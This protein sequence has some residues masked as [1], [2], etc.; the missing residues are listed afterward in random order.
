MTTARR[1]RIHAWPGIERALAKVNLP[2]AMERAF[3]RYS[4]QD[5]LVTPVGELL[6]TKPSGE[7]HIKSGH[8]LGDDI[9]VVKVATG[10]YDNARLGL[11]TSSGVVLAFSAKT[12]LPTDILLDEG[13]LT[14][15]R[16]AAAGAVAAKYLAPKKV[17]AIGILGSGT[18]SVLQAQHL[19]GVTS[20]RAIVLWGRTR[21]AAERCAKAL[22]RDG[23]AVAIVGTPEDVVRN[24][25][26][27]VTT[28]ASSRALLKG[29]D[30]R[31]GTHITAVGADTAEKQELDASVFASADI[32]AAD[33]VEQCKARGDLRHALSAGTVS[34]SAVRELGAIIAKRK[35]RTSD[36][37]ITIA[38]LTGVATQDVE[39]AKAVLAVLKR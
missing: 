20:C 9:F 4:R 15:I 11:P 2:A 34:L 36:R 13:R 23:F 39:I 8:I 12:G 5:A 24:A 28:T 18:Q 21:K 17:D 33:S 6:F 16:T 26:L 35:G 1:P 14:N 30:I 27:I 31:P 38:D 25:N 37:Q 3:V 22:R 19:R 7:A 10:F 32:V 29:A